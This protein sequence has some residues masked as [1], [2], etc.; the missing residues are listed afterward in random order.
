MDLAA[1]EVE[2]G[3]Y[4]DFRRLTLADGSQHV[5]VSRRS[6]RTGRYAVI[7]FPEHPS[8]TREVGQLLLSLNP[9]EGAR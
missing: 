5:E 8:L 4:L 6:E 7:T 9:Q 2:P 3:Q 1:F